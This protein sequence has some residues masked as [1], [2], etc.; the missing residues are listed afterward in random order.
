MAYK[1]GSVVMVCY[2]L[3]LGTNLESMKKHAMLVLAWSWMN[4]IGSGSLEM[5]LLHGSCLHF[6]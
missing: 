6:G 3:K 4:N 1:H 5:A 2:H